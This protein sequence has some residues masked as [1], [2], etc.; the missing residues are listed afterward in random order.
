MTN[1]Y[2]RKLEVQGKRTP[3]SVR[4]G[5]GFVPMRLER[6]LAAMIFPFFA[7]ASIL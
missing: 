5:T 4:A 1:D 3:E 7:H 2:L 6:R